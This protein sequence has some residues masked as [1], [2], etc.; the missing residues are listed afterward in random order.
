MHDDLE[1]LSLDYEQTLETYR[2]LA[3]IRFKLLAFIPA[4]SAAA[5]TLLTQT[6]IDPWGKRALASLGFLVTLGIVLYDQRNTQF[7]NGAIGRAKHLE[8]E[9]KLRRFER[10]RNMGLFGSRS[11]HGQRYLFLLPVQH[12]LGLALIY[13]PVFGGWAFAFIQGGWPTRGLLAATVGFGLFGLAFVQFLWHDG[14]PKRL[15]K[16]WN[17]SRELVQCDFKKNGK[18]RRLKAFVQR[19]REVRTMQRD[20]DMLRELNVRIGEAEHKGNKADK[21]FLAGVV[22]PVLAF[23]RANGAFTDRAIFLAGIKPSPCR[24]TEIKSIEPMGRHSAVVTC[25]VSVIEEDRRT[26]FLNVR[27]FVKSD[28]SSWRLLGWTNEA[29]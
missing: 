12:D 29:I 22:A 15:N 7:Y 6:S 11:D 19:L 18:P 3:E 25:E 17:G 4:I 2:Q 16:Y 5:I 14:K 24:E 10:D 21:D 28:D 20:E 1:Q 13:S 9:L 8:E 27:L 23:R 26:R